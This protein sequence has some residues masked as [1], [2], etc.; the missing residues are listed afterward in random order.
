MSKVTIKIPKE[1][2]ENLQGMIKDTGFSSVTE[3]VVFVMRTVA[4]TGNLKEENKLTNDEIDA[5]RS[6]LKK[7]GY[8]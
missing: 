2:Y 1:L 8:I 6:R 7:L 5:I 3:F 4:S